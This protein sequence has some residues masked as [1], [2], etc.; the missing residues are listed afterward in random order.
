MTCKVSTTSFSTISQRIG[1]ATFTNLFNKFFG[2]VRSGLIGKRYHQR[3]YVGPTLSPQVALKYT[4]SLQFRIYTPRAL[5]EATRVL[6][7]ATST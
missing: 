4:N 6:A 2:D 5:F 1:E 3:Q 7:V